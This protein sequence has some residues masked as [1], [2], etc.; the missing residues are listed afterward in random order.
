MTFLH[1]IFYGCEN[2]G[3]KCHS[4]CVSSTERR[5]ERAGN[6]CA[7]SEC[8][9]RNQRVLGENGSNGLQIISL[10]FFYCSELKVDTGLPRP[11]LRGVI[12][13][14]TTLRTDA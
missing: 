12:D 2:G 5:S 6:T 14:L 11:H 13:E 3:A 7:S 1:G 10:W 9:Y 4:V 8:L